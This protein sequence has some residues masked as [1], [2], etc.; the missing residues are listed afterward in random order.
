MKQ[1]FTINRIKV[2]NKV[3]S[4]VEDKVWAQNQR[5]PNNEALGKVWWGVQNSINDKLDHLNSGVRDEI[6]KP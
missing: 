2:V 1:G 6:L 3:W 5:P 4:Q